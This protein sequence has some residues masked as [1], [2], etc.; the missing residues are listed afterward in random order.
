MLPKRAFVRAGG[1]SRQEAQDPPGHAPG[2]DV[3]RR[4]G[5]VRVDLR[6]DPVL[7]LAVRRAARARRHRDLSVPSVA[8][9]R[10]S[11]VSV[12]VTRKS[13]TLFS[14]FKD[15]RYKEAYCPFKRVIHLNYLFL[16]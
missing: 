8:A 9:I 16:L 2:A 5:R 7:L 15:E 14:A 1:E 11:V 6:P 3:R 12:Y 13:R 4:A 10:E